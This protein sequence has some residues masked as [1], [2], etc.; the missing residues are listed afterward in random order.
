M[1]IEAIIGRTRLTASYPDAYSNPNIVSG[2][3]KCENRVLDRVPDRQ[4]TFAQIPNSVMPKNNLT[5][6]C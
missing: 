5:D 2:R 3:A 1:S 4:T 6:T